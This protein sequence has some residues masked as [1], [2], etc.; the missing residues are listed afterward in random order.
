MLLVLGLYSQE[1]PGG[2]RTG[3]S[4][5]RLPLNSLNFHFNCLLGLLTSAPGPGDDVFDKGVEYDGVAHR[6]VSKYPLDAT[7]IA[8]KIAL[9]KKGV[10]KGE[11]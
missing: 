7:A 9:L 11:I 3:G 10:S 6:E 1:R 2:W 8:L 4:S 5:K